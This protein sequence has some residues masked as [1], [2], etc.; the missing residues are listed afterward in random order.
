MACIGCHFA[1]RKC[2]YD[3]GSTACQRCIKKKNKCILH[4][5]M[6]G[7]RNDLPKAK[8][9][10]DGYNDAELD[11]I[12]SHER[13]YSP[14]SEYQLDDDDEDDDEDEVEVEVEVDDED[15]DADDANDDDCSAMTASHHLEGGFFFG[16]DDTSPVGSSVSGFGYYE[17]HCDSKDDGFVF[18]NIDDNNCGDNN[19]DCRVISKVM[20]KLPGTCKG[21]RSVFEVGETND[22]KRYEIDGRY[23]MPYDGPVSFIQS[24]S[25]SHF[26]QNCMNHSI[27]YRDISSDIWRY[28]IVESI[29]YLQNDGCDGVVYL[30]EWTGP[31]ERPG[32]PKLFKCKSYD[33]M[34]PHLTRRCLSLDDIELVFVNQIR[35]GTILNIPINTRTRNLVDGGI[36]CLPT[37]SDIIDQSIIFPNPR[38]PDKNYNWEM[39]LVS[40]SHTGVS[41]LLVTNKSAN[42]KRRRPRKRR[43][44]ILDIPEHV[45]KAFP[46]LLKWLQGPK[47]IPHH[48]HK[49]RILVSRNTC[50]E[51][52]SMS[53]TTE[54]PKKDMNRF[55]LPVLSSVDNTES[56]LV[57]FK[58]VTP[59]T[60]SSFQK[61][62]PNGILIEDL[63]S[64]FSRQTVTTSLLCTEKL[65]SEDNFHGYTKAFA[66]TSAPPIDDTFDVI[67]VPDCDRKV[68][69]KIVPARSLHNYVAL[70]I[71]SE[72]I[73]AV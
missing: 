64:I 50:G 43:K 24:T 35:G 27:V 18:G 58:R 51:V 22:L 49:C 16:D 20:L 48:E 47:K 41:D 31:I 62:H 14:S 11:A 69:S 71:G 21:K 37:G 17:D 53:D 32:L 67:D 33:E 15:D 68:Y 19:S 34:I 3:I 55:Y 5:S 57:Q 52:L 9:E 44:K 63:P 28:A 6:Q 12:V 29:F 54:L 66:G 46:F 4:P 13:D 56:P 2:S 59:K 30:S 40:P 73:S 8:V 1:K 23:D 38:E 42:G 60:L 26:T 45:K 25:H 65:K 70:S 72:Y 61:S 39:D 36:Q 7:R 10:D